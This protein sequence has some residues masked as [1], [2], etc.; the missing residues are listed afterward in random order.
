MGLAYHQ[1]RTTAEALDLAGRLPEAEIIAGGTDLMVRMKKA[2][3]L[4]AAMISLRR[5]EELTRI[6]DGPRVAI[7]AAVPLREV[8]AHPTVAD[9]F[10]ALVQAIRVFGSPQIR[11]VATVGGNLCNASPGA[12]CAPPLL[13]YGAH[14]ALASAEGTREVA[15]EDFVLGP[16]ET[17]LR[18]G[19]ILTAVLLERPP[20]GARSMYV[21]KGRVQMDLAVV[22][23]AALLEVDG[24][25]CSAARLAAGAVAPVPLRLVQ[26]ERVVGGA[27]AEAETWTAARAAAQGEISPI[28]DVRASEQYRRHLTG[29]LVERSLAELAATAAGDAS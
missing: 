6:D 3:E 15:V 24:A 23:V 19:E 21:R 22:G 26:T 27:A 29:V 16:G 9:A 2:S 12:D 13:I 14:V 20:A 4:P 25:T 7:G 10:P 11:N 8:A 1:P 28:S 17:A 5:V 18:P